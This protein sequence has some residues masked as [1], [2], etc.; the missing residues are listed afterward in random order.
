[1]SIASFADLS[2]IQKWYAGRTILVTGGTGFMGKILL[3]KLIRALPCIENVY[4]LIRPKKNLTC[5]QRLA[6]IVELPVI[7]V[8]QK[9]ADDF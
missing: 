5:I 3:E 6:A 9:A 4:V 1:M 2:P 7:V 8:L